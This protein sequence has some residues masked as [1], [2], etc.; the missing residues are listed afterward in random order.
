MGRRK[1]REKCGKKEGIEMKRRPC[2]MVVDDEK[3]IRN[4]LKRALEAQGYQVVLAC[5][6]KKALSLYPEHSPDL[7]ILDI[8]MPELNG[9]ETLDAL[10]KSSDVPVIMLTGKGDT[11]SL[12]AALGLGADDFVRKPFHLRELLARIKA[13]MRRAARDYPSPPAN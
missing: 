1:E 7:V 3:E 10:R 8:L 6:G 2:L 9:M 13:K 12:Q 4:F 11:G 5:N